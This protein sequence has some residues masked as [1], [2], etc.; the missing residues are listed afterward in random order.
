MVKD[1]REFCLGD[2]EGE[3]GGYLVDTLGTIKRPF[4]EPWWSNLDTAA[5][6][7][8]LWDKSEIL[9]GSTLLSPMENS[10]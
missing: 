4:D 3:H 2:R 8:A 6:S 1:P 5:M 10:P 9:L 7:S